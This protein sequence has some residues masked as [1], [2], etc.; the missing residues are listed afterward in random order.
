MVTVT[1]NLQVIAWACLF[2]CLFVFKEKGIYCFVKSVAGLDGYRQ[3]SSL[4]GSAVHPLDSVCY[5]V[6][7]TARD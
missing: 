7:R 3:L 1:T 5:Q 2:I 4:D 6:I